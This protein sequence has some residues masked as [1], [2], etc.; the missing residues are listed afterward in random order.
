MKK[1]R[2]GLRLHTFIRASGGLAKEGRQRTSAFAEER[3]ACK[4]GEEN[5]SSEKASFANILFKTIADF[6]H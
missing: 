1:E 5:T 4:K 6:L 2:K 3:L